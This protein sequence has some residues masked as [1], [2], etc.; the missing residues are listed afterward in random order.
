MATSVTET[1]TLTQLALDGDP[2]VATSVVK[3]S[4]MVVG[5]VDSPLASLVIATSQRPFVFNPKRVRST[6]HR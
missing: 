3:G 6:V 4:F 1:P 2:G 5:G